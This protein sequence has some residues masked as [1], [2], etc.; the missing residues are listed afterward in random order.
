MAQLLVHY[1]N[2]IIIKR[3]KLRARQNY[4][5]LQCELI[6]IPE[7]TTKF[8][9]KVAKQICKEWQKRLIGSF[10]DST[11]LLRKERNGDCINK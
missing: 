9:M 1:L 2:P 4:R 6:F 5:S 3:L 8:S 10:S 7:S 11:E